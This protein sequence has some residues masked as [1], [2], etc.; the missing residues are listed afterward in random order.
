MTVLNHQS[1]FLDETLGLIHR[2]RSLRTHITYPS[3]I[4]TLLLVHFCLSTCCLWY[5]FHRQCLQNSSRSL[6]RLRS[7]QR[8]IVSYSPFL[9]HF[10]LGFTDRRIPTLQPNS[11]LNKSC[12]QIS[13]VYDFG[14]DLIW[15]IVKKQEFNS[16]MFASS[17]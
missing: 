14:F 9:T 16:M 11:I 2:L 10:S 15:L 8:F 3:Q 7:H 4:C 17:K 6:S 5:R 1:T 12:F 13:K